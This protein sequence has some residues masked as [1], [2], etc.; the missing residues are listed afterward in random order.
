MI[1]LP[2]QGARDIAGQPALAYARFIGSIRA[3]LAEG[4]RQIIDLELAMN[5]FAKDE[6]QYRL[7][8]PKIYTNTQ[9]QS[10]ADST[11]SDTAGIEDLDRANRLIM[12]NGNKYSTFNLEN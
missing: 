8:F 2:S 6:M 1:G 7:I 11:E 5:G 10:L 9:M 3:V 12:S 4:V